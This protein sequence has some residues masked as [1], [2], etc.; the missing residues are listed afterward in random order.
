MPDPCVE[1]EELVLVECCRHGASAVDH[2]AEAAAVLETDVVRDHRR[3]WISQRTLDIV[4]QR[5]L[6]RREI[7]WQEEKRLNKLV[8]KSARQDLQ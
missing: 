8:N 1:A 6:A 2:F 5:R 3:P 7:D 4:G